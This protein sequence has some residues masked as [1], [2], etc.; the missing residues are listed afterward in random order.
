[1]IHYKVLAFIKVASILVH[2]LFIG[3]ARLI[4]RFVPIDK[5]KSSAYTTQSDPFS[6]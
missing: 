1:M 2:K 5:N 3:L 4:D 6:S